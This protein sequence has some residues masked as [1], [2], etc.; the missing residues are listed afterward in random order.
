L[1]VAAA[2]EGDKVPEVVVDVVV[3]GRPLKGAVLWKLDS[4]AV[5]SYMCHQLYSTT[6]RCL[7]HARGPGRPADPARFR[8]RPR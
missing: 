5:Q 2:A 8:R 6:Q 3:L 1:G 7:W 4:F